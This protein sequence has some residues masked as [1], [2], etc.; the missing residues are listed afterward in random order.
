MWSYQFCIGLKF[1][2]DNIDQYLSFR[3]HA[4]LL[5]GVVLGC[6]EKEV[7]HNKKWISWP[8]YGELT[9]PLPPQLKSKKNISK[10]SAMSLIHSNKFYRQWKRGNPFPPNYHSTLSQSNII[11]VTPIG[12]LAPGSAH[13]WAPHWHERKFYGAHVC[14]V[15]FKHLP[16]Y[17]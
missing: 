10:L 4:F 3:A 14:R 6:P 2:C 17:F 1:G 8:F 13:A 15:T 16:Q 7:I 12:V 9:T 11:I 5:K